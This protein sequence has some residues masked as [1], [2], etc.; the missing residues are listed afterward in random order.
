MLAT[1]KVETM[2]AKTKSEARDEEGSKSAAKRQTAAARR[3]APT[4]A[5]LTAR[6]AQVEAAALAAQPRD[7]KQAR[8]SGIVARGHCVYDEPGNPKGPGMIVRAS[9][10]EIEKMRSRGVLVDEGRVINPT[11]QSGPRVLQEDAA[12]KGAKEG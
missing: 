7:N 10:P 5:Q 3:A 6:A 2:A 8:T 4:K 12:A 1:R 9:A 11:G